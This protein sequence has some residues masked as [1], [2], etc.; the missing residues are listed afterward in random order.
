MFSKM[1]LKE[2]C[3]SSEE[4]KA[5]GDEIATYNHLKVSNKDNGVK[6]FLTR[7]GNTCI[8]RSNNKLHLGRLEFK[9]KKC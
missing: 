8:T 5:N 1:R 6:R 7:T 2:H 9:K 3:V 4:E